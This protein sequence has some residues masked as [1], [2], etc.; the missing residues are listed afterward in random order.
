MGLAIFADI[1]FWSLTFTFVGKVLL[2]VTVINVHAH[3]IREHKIDQIAVV[4]DERRPVG[5]LDIQ[6]V[7]DIRH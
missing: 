4:D 2:G 5:L 1:L 7:L 6:D 3:I